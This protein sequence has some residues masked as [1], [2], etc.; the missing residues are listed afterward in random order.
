MR[1]LF[2]PVFAFLLSLFVVGCEPVVN[3]L[4]F[5]PDNVNIIPQETLPRGVEEFEVTTDDGVSLYSLYLPLP[6]S[7]KVLIYF[8]G[9][10]GNI[11]HRIPDLLRLQKAGVNVIGVSYRGYGKS[12]GSP[13]EQGLYHD[14][15]AIY[16]YATEKL[17][18]PDEDIIFFGRS[19]GTTVAVDLAQNK[20]IA[21]L[22]LVTPLTSAAEQAQSMGLGSVS[23]LAG[24]AFDNLSKIRD[25]I[26]PVL[27]IHGADDRVIPYSMGR[28][29]YENARGQ[30]RFVMIDGAGH[31]NLQ[32]AYA[33][34]YWPPV[35]E[36]IQQ[37]V[38]Y[39]K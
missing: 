10:A 2:I 31:N 33:A 15:K 39:S 19:I 13:S 25:V 11:Y 21:G 22:I 1:S 12:A 8:H 35:F 7:D 27:V 6:G 37:V 28:A 26:A 16:R 34:E 17:G 18:F 29:I 5:Y 20:P 30:K 3:A 38:D 24:N 32:D 36:F 14:G 9:N 4:A 23:S